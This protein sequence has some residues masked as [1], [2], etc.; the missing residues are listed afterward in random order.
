MKIDTSGLGQ[1]IVKAEISK[2]KHSALFCRPSGEVHLG[3]IQSHVT[4]AGGDRGLGQ[5]SWQCLDHQ[6]AGQDRRLK[7]TV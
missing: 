3:L 4:A 1:N 7:G 5:Q 2:H 6:Q